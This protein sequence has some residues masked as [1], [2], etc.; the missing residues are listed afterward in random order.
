MKCSNV[1]LN[2]NLEVLVTY[3]RNLSQIRLEE[4]SR[5]IEEIDQ[6][7]HNKGRDRLQDSSIRLFTE[8]CRKFL[9]TQV[10]DSWEYIREGLSNPYPTVSPDAFSEIKDALESALPSVEEVT[11]YFDGMDVRCG[12]PQLK[13]LI[14]AV[15][16]HVSEQR[17]LLL[18]VKDVE[19]RK[20]IQE[21]LRDETKRSHETP[22]YLDTKLRR[23]KDNR[24]LVW[25]YLLLLSFG[26][27]GGLSYLPKAVAGWVCGKDSVIACIK[28]IQIGHKPAKSAQSSGK[29]VSGKKVGKK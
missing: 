23:F 28:S 21:I 3:L 24:L 27:L 20:F 13:K 11:S 22:T 26:L 9:S 29:I 6:D 17:Q 19:I 4:H 2:D 10:Q 25:L 7:I 15:S 16:K 8:Q 5:Q 14:D 12:K 1:E 18:D